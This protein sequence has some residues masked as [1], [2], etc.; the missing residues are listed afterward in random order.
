[1]SVKV[2]NE[3]NFEKEVLNSNETVLVDFYADW[4][5]PC[6]A[7]SPIIDEIAEENT[8]IKVGK[9]NVDDNGELATEFD[10]IS[11]PTI[12]V[13]KNGEITKKFVGLTE[14]EA[15]KEVL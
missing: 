3:E 2:L 9:I 6:K 8:N 11:I 15:I 7:M 10:I 13:F 12:I 1:M 14:K 4:C 5:G